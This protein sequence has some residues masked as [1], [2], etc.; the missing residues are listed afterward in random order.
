VIAALPKILT[1]RSQNRQTDAATITKAYGA[2]I[3][4]LRDQ[5]NGQGG[6]IS[7][8]REQ[9]THLMGLIGARDQEIATLR[10]ELATE[11]AI[12]GQLRSRVE[13]L[14]RQVNG[15]PRRRDDPLEFH[16]DHSDAT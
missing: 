13:H 2:V 15:L 7:A 9:Q 5:V 12:N 8:L 11:R 3:D 10:T 14:E 6:E 1:A 16:R 4:Q